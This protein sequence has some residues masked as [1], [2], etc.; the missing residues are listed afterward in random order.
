MRPSITS[1]LLSAMF[2][3]SCGDDGAGTKKD[4]SDQKGPPACGDIWIAGETLSRDYTSCEA[5]DG[6]VIEAEPTPCTRNEGVFVDYRNELAAIA[7]GAIVEAGSESP[8]YRATYNACFGP[9][10]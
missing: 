7:G 9:G 6:E 5:T 10:Y 2:L 4:S 1:L 8:A 3:V